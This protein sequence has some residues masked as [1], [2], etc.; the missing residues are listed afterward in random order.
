MYNNCIIRE[1]KTFVEAKNCCKTLNKRIIGVDSFDD[2]VKNFN[3][4][5]KENKTK[6]NFW[7]RLMKKLKILLKKI[8]I[9]GRI[10]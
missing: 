4:L 5:N 2:K 9:V 3:K 7:V 6:L 1:I 8:Y 10:A